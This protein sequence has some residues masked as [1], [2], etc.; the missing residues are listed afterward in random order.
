MAEASAASAAPAATATTKVVTI[1]EEQINSSYVITTP[2][3]TKI[4][5][6]HVDLQ[7]GKVVL[8][9]TFTASDTGKSYA[10]STTLTPTLT[11]GQVL[12]QATSASVG[13]VAA[14]DAKLAELNAL[15]AD[16][17]ARSYKTAHG[18]GVITAFEV[19]DTALT[20]T[21]TLPDTRPA[22]TPR[23]PRS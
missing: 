20:Y 23:V 7:P 8:T 1:T 10:L 5:D 21:L 19:S 11:S 15:I 14:S 18:P 16:S 17:W 13:K 6:R 22:R 12:W 3:S 2:R 9:A 4:T